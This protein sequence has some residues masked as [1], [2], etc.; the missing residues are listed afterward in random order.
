[1]SPKFKTLYILSPV[2]T[3]LL[4]LSACQ[5]DEEVIYPPSLA[6][7]NLNGQT[8]VLNKWAGGSVQPSIGGNIFSV[9]VQTEDEKWVFNGLG[10]I[11]SGLSLPYTF[12]LDSNGVQFNFMLSYFPNANSGIGMVTYNASDT[13]AGSHTF[14]QI[15]PASGGNLSGNLNYNL[16]EKNDLGTG[17]TTF[18]NTMTAEFNFGIE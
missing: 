12:N 8:I 2:L 11:Q 18:N 5:Q 6:V 3:T 7:V 10:L 17:T 14:T 13:T 15:N 1:M 9:S 16:V 4:L